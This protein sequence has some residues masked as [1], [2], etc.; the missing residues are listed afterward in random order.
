MVDKEQ[1]LNSAG[2]NYQEII[3]RYLK[4]QNIKLSARDRI[5]IHLG[6]DLGTSYTKVV[7]RLGQQAH[8]VCF[9]GQRSDRLDDYLVPSIVYFDGERFQT[10]L[11]G[12]KESAIGSEY[13]I[14]NF[15]ICLACE[16]SKSNACGGSKCP[17]SNWNTKLFPKGMKDN[18]VELVTSLFLASVLSR[19][20]QIILNELEHSTGL[21][22]EE[23]VRW[24]VNLA[25]P[26]K[27]L[28][29]LPIASGFKTALK[30]AW[31]M[32]LAMDEIPTIHSSQ[33]IARCYKA[34]RLLA[35][36]ND[37]DCFV[38]SEVAAEVA[39]VTRSRTS[40][41]GLYTFVDIGAG[42][43]DASVFRLYAPPQGDRAHNEYAAEVLRNG[44]SFIEALAISWFNE[45]EWFVSEDTA[46]SNSINRKAAENG[47][48]ECL[49][50]M[51]EN[52]GNRPDTYRLI[53]AK[54]LRQA[55]N[56]ASQLIQERVYRELVR[57]FKE[58]FS[59]QAQIGFWHDLK[60][61]L[62]GGG[63]SS[64]AYRN[65][66]IEAFTLKNSPPK[67]PELVELPKPSDFQMNELSQRHF[68]R[69]AVAYGLSYR[70]VDL[71]QVVQAS[72][73]APVATHTTP[74][75]ISA[76]SKDEC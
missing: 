13:A 73:V 56:E 9:F 5:D 54:D 6:L 76:P 3:E 11:D 62:G 58:A 29:G 32:S 36:K 39:S 65:A 12:L 75:I 66:A 27:Y 26:D 23:K 10:P 40:Q 48:R 67:K 17:I 43:V 19:S 49:R 69:F 25:V 44:S 61:I 15:K 57:L 8:P 2:N 51:K 53:E 74:I 16:S 35:E 68:H 47:L 20:K 7:W 30:T 63:A 50:E 42:T 46:N 70:K 1:D 22:Q 55:L 60:L 14:P 31:L 41:D 45:N 37:L 4:K 21:R 18:E 64:S 28:A 71:P 59:K 33:E 38:Y 24:S 72:Q 34:A 52:G